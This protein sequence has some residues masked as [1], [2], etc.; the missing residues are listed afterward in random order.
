MRLELQIYKL[1]GQFHDCVTQRLKRIVNDYHCGKGVGTRFEEGP[2]RILF[3]TDYSQAEEEIINGAYA[4]LRQEM[5]AAR[6]VS[7]KLKP[8]LHQSLMTVC[9]F[10]G[11]RA[12]AMLA[13]PFGEGPTLLMEPEVGL[14]DET[15][16]NTLKTLASEMNLLSSHP[17]RLADGRILQLALPSSVEVHKLD[18][19]TKKTEKPNLKGTFAKTPAGYYLAN[20]HDIVPAYPATENLRGFLYFRPEFIESLSAPVTPGDLHPES[21]TSLLKVLR[22]TCLPQFLERLEELHFVP[23]DSEEWRTTLHEAGL[24][25]AL[26]GAIARDTKLPHIREG[27]VIEMVARTTKIILRSRV[28]GAILHF[29]E[30]Q[31]LRVEEELKS[32]VLEIING[33]ITS[34]SLWMEEIMSLVE[35]RFG[36]SVEVEFYQ[37]LSRN[38]LLMALQHHCALEFDD[39]IYAKQGVI[40]PEDFKGFTMQLT[41]GGSGCF[42]GSKLGSESVNNLV[43]MAK[44]ILPAGESLWAMNGRRAAASRAILKVVDQHIINREWDDAMRHAELASGMS[45]RQHPQQIRISLA[46]IT[47]RT[48]GPAN[49]AW[50]PPTLGEKPSSATTRDELVFEELLKSKNALIF[51]VDRHFGPHHPLGIQLRLKLAELMESVKGG[52]SE[53]LKIRTEALNIS[54]KVLGRRHGYSRAL[55][56]RLANAHYQCGNYDDAITAYSEAIKLLSVVSEDEEGAAVVK[57]EVLSGMSKCWQAKGDFEISLEYSSQCRTHLEQNLPHHLLLEQTYEQL[58][59]LSQSIYSMASDKTSPSPL[60]ALLHEELIAEPIVEHLETAV[61][62][63]SRLFDAR[64]QRNDLNTEDGEELLRL[65]RKIVLLVLRLASPPQ[66]PA[67]RA[68][69]R[70]RLFQRSSAGDL[71]VREAQVRELLVR[72]ASGPCTP[73]EL[74]ERVLQTAENVE[75]LPEAESELALMLDLI[76]LVQ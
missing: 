73:Q 22:D 29:R 1:V 6:W 32:I 53:A 60:T 34:S 47:I 28:R 51:R 25:V 59:E 62:C 41:D 40:G 44:I 33:V 36:Y 2:L 70:K 55:L 50:R 66:R 68:L 14:V 48:L 72:M 27:A 8:M 18:R 15:A 9:E 65:A 17:Y 4:W 7:R 57:A 3:I 58:A 11:F 43:Q 13:L 38:A 75:T 64:R 46:I 5:N 26:L 54:N 10:K 76:E 31:A 16:M 37:N 21:K 52:C 23:L 71:S 42:S 56:T 61:D 30:V 67:I 19:S 20:V 39:A 63:Y 35:D 49:L 45:S 24:N 12:L 74:V 69:V